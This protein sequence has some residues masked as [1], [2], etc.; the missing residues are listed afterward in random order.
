MIRCGPV[1]AANMIISSITPITS[2]VS[3]TA[4]VPARLDVM[5]A[6]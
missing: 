4:L 6:P 2:T 1:R 5:G 3:T